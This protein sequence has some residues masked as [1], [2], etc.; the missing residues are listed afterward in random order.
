MHADKTRTGLLWI[1]PWMLGVV[2]FLLVPLGMSLVTSFTD[3]S[4]L[5]PRAFVGVSNYARA[6][7]D[8]VLWRVLLNTMVYSV[9][10]VGASTGLG[11]L[12]AVLL[13]RARVGA[14]A[15]RAI[16]FLPSV[17]PMAAAG[18]LWMW[19]LSTE[20]GLVNRV[21]RPVLGLAGLQAPAWL[22]T[23]LGAMVSIVIVSTWQ[24]GQT[25]VIYQAAL[26]QVPR[27]QLEAASLDGATGFARL[28][29]VTLPAMWHVIFFS[30]V[31]G[32]LASMQSFVVPYV[33]T[34]GGPGISTRMYAMEL[35][36]RAF[37]MGPQM[38]YACAL[39]WLQMLLVTMLSIVLFRSKAQPTQRH[40]GRTA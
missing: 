13:E 15:A 12:L 31:T 23:P 8:S 36:E 30:I 25:V 16:V 5:E 18:V 7:G 27:S 21:L 1:L 22:Q 24:I 40:Q 10:C 2:F 20:Q 35:Y 6:L 33:M 37:L 9:L 19:M 28:W 14:L 4:I 34:N 38:G 29:H 17:L 39:A 11:L 32:I 3:D 26:R